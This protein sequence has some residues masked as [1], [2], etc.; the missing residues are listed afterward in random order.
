VRAGRRAWLV[1]VAVGVVLA[2]AGV[3]VVAYGTGGGGGATPRTW[4]AAGDSYSSGEGLPHAT[5]PCARALPGSGSTTWMDGAYAQ[6]RQRYRQ[7]AAPTSV[8]CTGATTDAFMAAADRL[9]RPEWEPAMGT[10]DLVTFT[11]GGDDVGFSAV[12]EQ[13]L[14]AGRVASDV[15]GV[16][17]RAEG[18]PPPSALPSDPGHRCPSTAL[19]A[20]RISTL[21]GTLRTFLSAVATVAVTHGGN[22]VVLGYPDL[23][24]DPGRWAAPSASCTGLRAADATELRALAGDLD[25]ALSGAAGAVDRQAPNGVHVRYVPVNDAPGAAGADPDLFEPSTGDRHNLCAPAPWLNGLTSTGFGTG[26]FHPEQVG[27]DHEANLAARAIGH[28][29]WSGLAHR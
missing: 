1:I 22:I 12:L 29:D 24:E 15:R 27:L 13:C 8:A 26:S 4:L 5:G 10:F 18:T 7:L 16:I 19:L 6:L 14:G 25:Q 28:L 17:A 11:F 21:S 3:G 23:V 20:S 9:G 2:V